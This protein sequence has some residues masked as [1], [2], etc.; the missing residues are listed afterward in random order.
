MK[1]IH[2]IVLAYSG[3]LDT[4]VILKWLQETYHCPVVA[5]CADIGQGEE[6]AEVA[7]KARATGAD[8]VFIEDL[9]EE[10]V[11]DFVWPLFRANALYEGAYLLGTAIARP[12]IAKAQV[13]VA[14]KTGADAVSH[15]ATGKGNDQVRFELTYQALAPEL[16]IIAPWREWDLAGRADCVA[17]AKKH[18]IPVPVTREKPYS[19]DRNLLHLSFE[20]GVLEDPW[21]EPPADMFVLTTSPEAAP[22]QPQYVEI[23]FEA[24][25]PVAVDGEKLSPATLLA[26]LNAVGG[27]HGIGRVDLVENRYVGLKSRGVYETPGGTIL[28]YA[29]QAVESLTLDREMLHLRDSLSPRYAELV[30]Y[31]Y[32]YA[33]ERY[34]LQKLMDEAQQPVTGTARLK[35]YKGNVTVVGR[36]APKSLYQPTLV[37]FEAG[38]DY[39]QADA[40]GFIRLNA[41]RLKIRAKLEGK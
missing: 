34:A 22:D 4:S 9:Q 1:P 29:H 39:R 15:G 27:E 30:Y 5:F 31:G 23:D 28:R 14:H 41:L 40:T 17:Y 16:I 12:L 11:R 2:K 32:W 26:R 18:G 13:E 33:P 3:G 35:L 19:S 38:G 8:E 37:T 6:V 24:G 21:A 25:D 36:K 10:F 20:G 7:A